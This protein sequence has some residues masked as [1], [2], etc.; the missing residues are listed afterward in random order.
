MHGR[1]ARIFG[2][3]FDQGFGPE[4]IVYRTTGMDPM[5]K[6]SLQYYRDGHVQF[7]STTGAE[8]KPGAKSCNHKSHVYLKH[9]TLCISHSNALE[10][11]C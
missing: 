1:H 5:E 4:N 7:Y 11:P 6:Y 10:N 8:Q 9:I 3:I 2:Q